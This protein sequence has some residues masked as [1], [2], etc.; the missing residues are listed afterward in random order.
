M[1]NAHPQTWTCM[2]CALQHHA[3]SCP[4][5]QR[6]RFVQPSPNPGQWLAGGQASILS[7]LVSGCPH[8][9][10][11]FFLCNSNGCEGRH[12]VC[13]GH[14]CH[15][16]TGWRQAS[17]YDKK[18]K[19]NNIEEEEIES[20]SVKLIW[21]CQARLTNFVKLL[22]TRQ[23]RRGFCIKNKQLWKHWIKRQVSCKQP[24]TAALSGWSCAILESRDEEGHVN[25]EQP[26][27][28]RKNYKKYKIK[29]SPPEPASNGKA[30]CFSVSSSTCIC[31]SCPAFLHLYHMPFAAWTFQWTI[32]GHPKS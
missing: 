12:K 8:K 28:A 5:E 32:L 21:W 27:K 3:I 20:T 4:P 24:T 7:W 23:Q 6:R 1:S 9:C 16:S 14:G 19:S 2:T 18:A 15:H 30:L 29:R 11:A 10:I 31:F 22:H 25:H 17:Q 13:N 26:H